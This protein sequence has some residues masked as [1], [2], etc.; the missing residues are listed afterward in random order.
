MKKTLVWSL[1]LL[2]ILSLLAGCGQTGGSGGSTAAETAASGTAAI[3]GFKT[4]GDAPA[5]G[6]TEGEQYAMTQGWFIYAFTLDGTHYRVIAQMPE[7]VYNEAFDL[8]WSDEDHDAKLQ[9]LISPIEIVRYENLDDMIPAQEELDVYVGKTLQDMFDE[10]WY[11]SG[12]NLEDMVFWMN[13]GPFNYAV[14]VEG[15]V[16]NYDDFDE[17]DMGPLVIKSVT[18]EGLGDATNVAM[19]DDGNLVD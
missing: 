6:T 5:L 14:A 8:D 11:N 16:E 10:G 4:L 17:E 15:T 9:E 7:D 18:Y 12:W 19:D 1:A 13:H 3:E 2:L